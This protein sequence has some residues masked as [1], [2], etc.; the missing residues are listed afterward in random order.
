MCMCEPMF[1]STFSGKWYN[2]YM[3]G[4][5][6]LKGCACFRLWAKMIPMGHRLLLTGRC[7]FP[8]SF[9]KLD[10]SLME[11]SSTTL[12][13]SRVIQSCNDMTNRFSRR[14]YSQADN[15]ASTYHNGPALT[16]TGHVGDPGPGSHLPPLENVFF[17]ML[18]ARFTANLHA[19][20]AGGIAEPFTW[21]SLHPEKR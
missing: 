3:S 20:Q 12:I 2:S 16:G 18:F 7:W 21:G 19:G 6:V 5:V 9:T 4:V 15:R 10:A 11:A 14:C 1:L 13:T 17:P 8:F